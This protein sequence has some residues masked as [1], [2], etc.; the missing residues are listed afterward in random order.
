MEQEITCHI[1]LQSPPP[2]TD[3][4]LQKG[5]G[6]TYE[7]VQTQRSTK[8][9][10]HF[11]CPIRIKKDKSGLPDFFGPFAQGINGQR[12]IYIDIGT[13]A[14]QPEPAWGRRLKIPL[15]GI[16]WPMIDQ[17]IAKPGAVLQTHVPGTGKDGTPACATVK[18]FEGWRVENVM[19]E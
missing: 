9:D 6:N 19:K 3:F 13:Y 4:G 17:L 11:S 2:G 1:I 8:G 18:L 14:G 7:T 16:D 15:T 5:G 10:L 12:F